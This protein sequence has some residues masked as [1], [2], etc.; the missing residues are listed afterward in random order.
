MGKRQILHKLQRW[1]TLTALFLALINNKENPPVPPY[2]LNN[3]CALFLWAWCIFQ[4][5]SAMPCLKGSQNVTS[6]EISAQQIYG[7]VGVL[8]NNPTILPAS[9]VL[10]PWALL[11]LNCMFVFLCWLLCLVSYNP[12]GAD[13][14]P[15]LKK[16][17][18]LYALSAFCK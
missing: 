13:P 15:H 7:R 12:V 9:Q 17:K 16:I 2:L 1:L 14:K 5:S 8:G 6:Q 3:Y 10:L 11:S 4:N 18:L